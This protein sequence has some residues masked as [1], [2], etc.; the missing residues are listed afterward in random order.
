MSE[1]DDL[2]CEGL[3]EF[4]AKVP[5]TI[6]IEGVPYACTFSDLKMDYED[7]E[8]GPYR[9]TATGIAILRK[10]LHPAKPK[11]ETRIAI[12]GKTARIAGIVDDGPT[13][14]LGIEL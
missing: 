11:D 7:S 5:A 9:A 4:E 10:D 12:N 14:N 13:W 2:I 3:K 6:T 8:L 1:F